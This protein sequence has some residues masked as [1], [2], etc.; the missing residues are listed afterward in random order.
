MTPA[1]PLA[2]T[3]VVEL[4]TAIT[5][6]YV[7]L[8]LAD[9]G[10]DVI[11]VESPAGDSFRSWGKSGPSPRFL[12]FNRNKRSVVLDLRTEEGQSSFA[13]LLGSADVFVSNY[14][15]S[16]LR[17]L[18]AD[19]ETVMAM[20]PRIVYCEIT[21][22]G[23]ES[24]RPMYDAVAQGLTGLMSMV[25]GADDPRPRGPAITDSITGALSAVA[26]CAALVERERTGKGQLVRAS[27][28][29]SCL[30]FLAESVTS[31]LEDGESPGPFTRPR[32]SQSYGFVCRDG[33]SLVVHMSTPAK[34][35]DG[36]L[37]VVGR[38]DLHDDARFANYEA[39]IANYDELFEVLAPIFTKAPLSEWL[40][41][42]AQADVP[43]A[44]VNNLAEALAD[45]A[46][47]ALN[48]TPEIM[49]QGRPV[50]VV[51]RP[52]VLEAA[53]N[54]TAPPELGEHTDVVFAELAGDTGNA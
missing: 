48:I 49:I 3:V 24:D 53:A 5:A 50:A 12:A 14:R 47:A 26:V 46:V 51:R 15:P 29:Q 39:R 9:L 22:A 31:L 28:L 38:L 45:P 33:R 27:M 32:Y 52:W 21:G 36:L 41:R 42:L 6:P 25:S 37:S 1:G 40:E 10:A 13:T 20:H 4:G 34:F 23:P 43:A 54:Y 8:L 7:A 17:R 44:P 19:H 2:G 35:W 30:S 11:K 18:T 16:A